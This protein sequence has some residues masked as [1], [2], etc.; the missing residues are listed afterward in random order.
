MKAMIFAAG[1]GTRLRPLT[2][3][4]PK[5]LVPVGNKPV[6]LWNIEYLK[7]YGVTR[8]IVNAH[9]H[10]GQ[11]LNFLDGGRP[12]GIPIEVREESRIL[13]T[14]G[15]IKNTEDFWDD[16]PFVVINSDVITNIPLDRAYEYHLKSDALA[17]LVLHDHRPYNKIQVDP[18]GC[19]AEIP[20][21]Y[22]ARGLAF[23]G[24]HIINPE[25][26]RHIPENDFSDIIDCYRQLIA[27]GLPVKAFVAQGHFWHDI[28][29]LPSYLRANRKL[30]SNTFAM[31]PKTRRHPSAR[32][33]DWAVIG[34]RCS[35]EENTI[36][37][38]CVLWEGVTIKAGQTVVDSVLTPHRTVSLGGIS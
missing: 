29:D 25:L 35:L 15:G 4:R 10:S 8:I 38:R 11:V 18:Q 20:R 13:G 14:G 30:A 9:H 22:G 32:L 26:L 17:T 2:D 27:S 12:F 34:A 21:A 23:T 19:I 7:T 33:E 24:I 1:L 36:V 37:K 16:A 3:E 31:A 28:G 6:I 5:A